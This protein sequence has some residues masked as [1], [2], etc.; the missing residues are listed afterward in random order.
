MKKKVL[1]VIT[2]LY[3][4]GAERSLVSL[5]QTMDP[6]KY[7]IDLLLFK[8]MGMF[9][10]Q[11]P[12]Y[13]NILSPS[14]EMKL[15][16]GGGEEKSILYNSIRVISTGLSKLITRS[17]VGQRQFRWKYFYS[18][19]IKKQEKKYDTAVAYMEGEPIYYVVDKINANKKV[20]WIHNDYNNLS[21]SS[22]FDNV[23]LSK[24][25]NIVS[26]SNKCVDILKEIFPQYKNKISYI[27]NLTSS[28]AIIKMADEFFPVEFKEG[29]NNLL[30]IGRLNHQ[31]GFDLAIEAG[32]Y[33]SDKGYDFKWFIIGDGMLEIELRKLIEK[34]KLESKIILL[35]AKENPYPYIKN[36]D[37]FV[38]PSRFEGKSIALDEA[39]IL[40]KPI[41]ITNYPT[42]KDQLVNGKEGMIVDMKPE[43]IAAGISN[44]IDNNKIRIELS[45]YLNK[46]DYGN[47]D[48]IGLYYSVLN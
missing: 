24:V 28:K 13:V 6:E 18:K 41:L 26:V 4:G 12:D 42:A 19:F 2:T 48:L 25:N 36:C 10:T 30:S 44:L 35:G 14:K 32:K 11:V 5:L 38:Q 1:F 40:G 7:D 8:E 39:K 21:C 23:Y 15:L 37:I 3:N 22:R 29:S 16:Y 27:P 46:L 9:L 47:E 45:N 34:Y 17:Y 20:A 33:L 31:K 43:K